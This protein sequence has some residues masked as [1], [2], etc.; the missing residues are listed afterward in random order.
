MKDKNTYFIF[1]D[2]HGEYDALLSAL[3]EAG[4]NESN[5]KHILVSAGDLFDR[6]PNSRKLYTYLRNHNAVFVKGN[7]DV[8]FQEYLEKGMDGEFVLFNILHNGLDAT[9]Q[10]FG[11]TNFGN[12]AVD[13]RLLED[14][15]RKILSNNP[16]ILLT[17]QS[18]PLYFETKHLII[19]H[20]GID[21]SLLNW[22]DTPE[23]YMLWDIQDS[24]KSCPNV[25]GKIIIIGHHHAFRV[26]ENARN[27]G[28]DDPVLPNNAT[29][30]TYPENGKLCKGVIKMYGNKDEHRP[31]IN[32]NKMAIDGCTNLTGKV[33]VVVIEDDP[34]EDKKPAESELTHQVDER[35]QGYEGYTFT[36]HNDGQTVYTTTWNPDVY[37][38]TTRY[39]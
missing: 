28:Y 36:V 10:S 17:L 32:G 29:Q 18:M 19:C 35:P 33:N 6:G 8:M 22:K 14:L 34:L 23:D 24:H 4:Y 16:T 3:E 11:G 12:G 38:T 31:Y 25:D 13:I 2:V 9:I 27:S 7:H 5:P 21:P 30:F 26:R 37:A 1:S 39:N 20:A 15:K